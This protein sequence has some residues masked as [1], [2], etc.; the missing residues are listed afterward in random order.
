MGLDFNLPRGFSFPAPHSHP[1]RPPRGFPHR[2]GWPPPPLLLL[3]TTTMIVL[4]KHHSLKLPQRQVKQVERWAAADIWNAIAAA[5]AAEAEGAGQAGTPAAVRGRLS[6]KLSTGRPQP[7]TVTPI[8]LASVL[9]THL[10]NITRWTKS[11]SFKKKRGHCVLRR[12][13][14]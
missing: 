6:Q 12:Y 4:S 7:L 13:F 2:H 11:T 8:L 14:G 10:V 9:N 5:A 3:K 1:H